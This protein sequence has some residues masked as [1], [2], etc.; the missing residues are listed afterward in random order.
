M[1]LRNSWRTI[2]E[3]LISRRTAS[4]SL[5]STRS[6]DFGRGKWHALFSKKQ[7][8]VLVPADHPAA[9]RNGLD[10]FVTS[11]LNLL[12][13]KAMLR[14]NHWLPGANLLPELTLPLVDGPTFL[15]QF[16]TSG[17]S[18]LAFLIGTPGP[19]Q[20]ASVLVMGDDG[21]PRAFAK[22]ALKETADTMISAEASW[23]EKIGECQALAG[24]APKLLKQGK[25][26]NGRH[27]LALSVAPSGYSTTSNFT[28][29]HA[30]FLRD[31]STFN[32]IES[33]F[34]ES[35][36]FCYLEHAL[37]QLRPNL[38][39]AHFVA[40]TNALDDCAQHFANWK[41]PFVLAHGDFAP[42]N[43]RVYNDGIFAFDWEYASDGASAL[44]DIFHFI[45]APQAVSGR[46]VT[47]G[48]FLEVCNQAH[49]YAVES[50]PNY[51]WSPQVVAAHGLAYLLHT[52]LMYSVSQGHVQES[53]PVIEAY[54]RLM[55]ERARWI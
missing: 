16:L 25:A 44:H 41:G 36:A 8:S 35:P 18:Q 7:R 45:L 33:S 24:K 21:G 12:Y 6:K 9:Q 38:S 46:G 26:S 17:S 31:L 13:A 15:D 32:P 50:H 28:A 10:F 20:K 40:L 54:W 27:Y 42:W 47:M 3:S 5:G 14:A 30:S 52:I 11:P 55:E 19:Y 23:L 49:R 37:S 43:I 48:S 39:E 1:E 22:V 4:H 53:H 51:D 34:R 29:A 2:S